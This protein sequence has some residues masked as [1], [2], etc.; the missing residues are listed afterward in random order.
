MKKISMIVYVFVLAVFVFLASGI[1]LSF[2]FDNNIKDII[3]NENEKIASA[4]LDLI[5]AILQNKY[6]RLKL[7]QNEEAYENS[8]KNMAI[9]ELEKYLYEIISEGKFFYIIDEN[10]AVL[11]HHSAEKGAKA[12]VHEKEIKKILSNESG[13][14]G[15]HTHG[16]T[17]SWAYF[18]EFKPWKWKIVYCIPLA[19]K[20]S[21]LEKMRKEFILAG[22]ICLL[23]AVFFITGAVYLLI[24]PVKKLAEE[25]K[26]MAEGDLERNVSTGG[27]GEVGILSK[28][29]VSMRDSIKKT[30][31]EL[32]ES[33]E[34]LESFAYASSH[35]LREPLRN[36][37]NYAQLLK[38]RSE[39]KLDAESKDFLKEIIY[40]VERMDSLIKGILAYAKAGRSENINSETD[41]AAIIAGIKNDAAIM[42]SAELEFEGSEMP[43][44]RGD[45]AALTSV[46]QNLIVNGI[47]FNRSAA[48]KIIV[49]SYLKGKEWVFEVIDNGIGIEKEYREKIFEVFQRLHS[50]SEFPGSGIGLSVC[51]KIIAR[52]GGKI[53]AEE[54]ND[55]ISGSVFKFTLPA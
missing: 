23:T 43:V 54:R 2:V 48:P 15:E 10:G 35:D 39:K 37:T 51:R 11:M 1:F 49:K 5:I 17:V 32:K 13:E 34:D 42:G 27:V 26:A 25:T 14:I 53:W 20:Y 40:S 46:F 41:I 18:R 8:F 16:D 31:T 30:I 6:D 4:K 7:T 29:F 22:I 33:N 45:K 52:H 21:M 9:K 47:K 50:S 44:V 19:L 38:M 36:I 28:N 24:R 3:D 55:G 12:P